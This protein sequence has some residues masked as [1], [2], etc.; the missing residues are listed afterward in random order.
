MTPSS[1]RLASLDIL[2]G[3]DLFLL[4]FF[5][6]VFIA[7]GQQLNL[8]WLNSILYQFDHEVWVGFRFWDLIMPL[9]LFMT[10]VSMPFSFA[11]YKKLNP[12][13]NSQLIKIAKRFL[14]LFLFGMI[15]QGNL[16]GF[17]LH[18]IYIYN[19]TLQ[20]IATGYLI[21]AI[22]LLHCSLKTQLISTALLLLIYWIPMT[23]AGDFSLEGNFAYK[24]DA[25]LLGRFRGD[26]TYTWIWSSLTF[27]VTVMLGTFAGHIMKEGKNKRKQVVQKLFIAGLVLVG[28][29]LLWSLQMPIIKRIWTGSMTLLSGGYCFLLMALFYYLIDYKGYSRGMNWLKVYGMNSITA[30]MLGEVINFR[31]IAASVSYGLKPYLGNY[32]S[33]WLTFANFLILFFILRMMY[34]KQCFLKI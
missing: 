17:D 8:P 18:H 3:F 13:N 1:T 12:K 5:Q 14:L 31:C 15:V 26:P 21:A 28:A 27:G 2:R 16:L 29:G 22:L 32:Y 4:V 24:V 10:G 23:F 19:N 9:F 30:Y 6:P 34:K 11:K 7:L 25:Y 20:A 33:V